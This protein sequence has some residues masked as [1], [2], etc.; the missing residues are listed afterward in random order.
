MRK[1]ILVLLLTVLFSFLLCGCSSRYNA[2][3]AALQSGQTTYEQSFMA[4]VEETYHL[5]RVVSIAAGAVSVGISAVVMIVGGEQQTQKAKKAI[6]YTLLAVVAIN[7]LPYAIEFGKTL[8][9]NVTPWS[10]DQIS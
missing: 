7:L 9:P 3:D 2:E 5:L 4:Y 1:H 6:L 8:F 10:P